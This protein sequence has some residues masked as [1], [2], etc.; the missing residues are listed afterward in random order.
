[1]LNLFTVKNLKVCVS[2]SPWPF[3]RAGG[4]FL[5][6]SMKNEALLHQMHI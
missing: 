4:G 6:I 1:M 2:F 5:K 3:I